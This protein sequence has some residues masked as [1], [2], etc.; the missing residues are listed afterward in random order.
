MSRSLRGIIVF[1]ILSA[2]PSLATAKRKGPAP[3]PSVTH[4]GVRYQV[5]HFGKSRGL[6]QN[7]GL[8]EAVD[9]KTGKRLWVLTVYKIAYDQRTEADKQDVFIVSMAREGDSLVVVNE[10]KERYRVDLKTRA[11]RR[12]AAQGK[13]PR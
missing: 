1:F 7:G 2:V 4:E 6:G 11:V 5:I 13:P 8:L 9:H 3:V 10:A 12:V